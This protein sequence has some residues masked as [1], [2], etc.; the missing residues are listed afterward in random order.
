[1]KCTMVEKTMSNKGKFN[2]VYRSLLECTVYYRNSLP[3]CAAENVISSFCKIPLEGDFQERYIMGNISAA[4]CCCRFIN[5][6]MTSA[7][8]CLGHIIRMQERYLE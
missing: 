5:I 2:E 1:M 6:Y 4:I 7:I 8:K 3:L